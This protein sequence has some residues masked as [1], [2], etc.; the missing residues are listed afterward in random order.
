MIRTV[1]GEIAPN[2]LGVTYMHE[3]LII[4]SEIVAKDFKHIHLPSVADAKSEL[5]YCKQAGVSA[6]VDCMPTGSGRDIKKLAEISKST[7]IH[8][9]AVTG[10]HTA[11]YYQ[12]SDVLVNKNTEKLADIFISEITNGCEGTQHKAG[13]IKVATS[14]EVPSDLEVRLF[15]AA[16]IAHNATGAPILTHCE[17]GNGA[18]QQINIF[19][20]L[21]INLKHIVLSHTDKNPEFNYHK[22]ILS[23]GINVEYDQSL[24]Q[25][26]FEEPVSALLT[27]EMFES[28][29]GGQIMLGT[30]GARRSLWKSLGGSPGLSALYSQ[31]RYKLKSV[32]M[33]D[34][35]LETLF[36]KNP[37]K[38]LS[39]KGEK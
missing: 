34:E 35:K 29:F 17:H 10:L 1:L 13:I 39:F 12:S 23:S 15:E 36:V 14:G 9:I 37:A 8:L 18:I 25:I 7:G 22:E 30:D 32:G 16:A 6:M 2:E 27:V 38:F 11:K 26:E 4:D 28:G 31:W 19:Q 3:H 5:T 24:R 33:T 20:K 21:G